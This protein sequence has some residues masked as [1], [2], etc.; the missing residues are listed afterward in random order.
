MEDGHGTKVVE[1]KAITSDPPNVVRLIS[2]EHAVCDDGD[3]AYSPFM[4]KKSVWNA[5]L[6][7]GLAACSGS[8]A[9]DVHATPPPEQTLAAGS[10][11]RATIQ[12]SL[13]SR[14][15]NRGDTLH[16][17]VSANI[18]G[19]H[20]GVVIPAGS[21][22][23]LVVARIEPGTDPRNPQGNMSLVVNSVTVNGVEYPVAAALDPVPSHLQVRAIPS[24]QAPGGRNARRDVIVSAG[25]PIVFSLTNTLVV[26]AR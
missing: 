7:L 22:A 20:G 9:R 25:T 18:T 23:T 1:S 16:A 24:D 4:S 19:P 5:V 11:V 3:E 6:A 13:S 8:A 17:I 10:R 26:T 14:L 21:G 12:D 15:N 2:P